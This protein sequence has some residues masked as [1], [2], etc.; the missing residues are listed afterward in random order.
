MA[1]RPSKYRPEMLDTILALMQDGASLVEVCA[2]IGISRETCAQWQ[3]PESP[4]YNKT[5]SDTIKRGVELSSAWW[6]RVGRTNLKDRDFNYTGWYMN[7]KNRFGWK[8]KHELSGNKE[9]P[10]ELNITTLRQ[11]ILK[12]LDNAKADK[13]AKDKVKRE[14]KR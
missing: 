1:G 8:D 9:N 3:N 5:F 10:L 6:E 7:M 13:E 11:T 2:E 14:K 4:W 12:D